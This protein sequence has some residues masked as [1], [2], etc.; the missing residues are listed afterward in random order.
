[1]GTILVLA[2]QLFLMLLIGRAI[3]SWI[4]IGP[5]HMLAPMVRFFHT[6]TEPVLGP[7]RRVMPTSGPI[8]VSLTAAILVIGFVLIPIA[9]RL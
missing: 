3:F 9:S 7:I 4:R 1:M 2:L 6:S 8:D 5:D